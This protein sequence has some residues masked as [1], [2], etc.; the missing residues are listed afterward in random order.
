MVDVRHAIASLLISRPSAVDDPNRHA[1]GKTKRRDVKMWVR[2]SCAVHLDLDAH[3]NLPIRELAPSTQYGNRSSYVAW[4]SGGRFQCGVWFP[5]RRAA[6]MIRKR[7][8]R[9]ANPCCA[10]GSPI[11]CR[12]DVDISAR[13]WVLGRALAPHSVAQEC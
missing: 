7:R 11:E 3:P 9:H 2:G 8:A 13:G 6:C 10:H 1:G 5:R 12:G 4:H